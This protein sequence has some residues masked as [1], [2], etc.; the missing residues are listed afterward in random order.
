VAYLLDT[1]IVIY[2]LTDRFPQ[3]QEQID[4]TDRGDIF[5]SAIG[6]AELY[7][8][9]RNSGNPQENRELIDEL[10]SWVTVVNFD[11]AAGALFGRIKAELKQAGKPV[12]DSDLFIAATAISHNLV[13]VTNNLRHFERIV[14]L[15][16]ENWVE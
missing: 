1:D 5:L 11:H 16:V 9:A 14:S 10:V 12:N 4:R 15:R 8:G 3:I 13:L 6:V 2:W 7:F